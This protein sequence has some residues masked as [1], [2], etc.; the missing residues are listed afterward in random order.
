MVVMK[1]STSVGCQAVSRNSTDTFLCNV[2]WLSWTTKQ[3]S[4]EENTHHSHPWIPDLAFYIYCSLILYAERGS[5]V[6]HIFQ[7]TQNF[8]AIWHKCYDAEFE[9]PTDVVMYDAEFEFPTDVV[10]NTAIFCNILPCSNSVCVCVCVCVWVHA[11][12]RASHG[13][14]MTL[15]SIKQ[16]HS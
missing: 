11:C 6:A 9:F 16:Q 14:C 12:T 8:R 3:H 5:Q 13:D 1:S 10:M 4:P 7:H 2:N 15:Y